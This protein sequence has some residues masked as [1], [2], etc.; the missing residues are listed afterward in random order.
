M[1]PATS[2]VPHRPGSSPSGASSLFSHL[3][4]QDAFRTVDLPL[5][6]RLLCQL[7]Y[8]GKNFS[9]SAAPRRE[10]ARKS[11]PIAAPVRLRGHTNTCTPRAPR[12][13]ARMHPKW[14]RR[15]DSNPRPRRW[16]R[17]AL[18][19]ELRLQFVESVPSIQWG[20][21]LNTELL[22]NMPPRS[23]CSSGAGICAPVDAANPW[24]LFALGATPKQG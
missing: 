21:G 20:W 3:V 9:I 4:P 11:R 19:A 17:R 10:V 8:K 18:P 5:T 2:P 12:A 16:Q 1:L 23:R 22:K 15:R 6:R 7:S 24:R 14:S 13:C